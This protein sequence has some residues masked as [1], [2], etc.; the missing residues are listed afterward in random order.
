MCVKAPPSFF[1]QLF[2]K[3]TEPFYLRQ[4]A[5]FEPNTFCKYL[6]N[7]FQFR[8]NCLLSLFQFVLFFKQCVP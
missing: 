5:F 8:S 4:I 2:N 6:L 1:L 7:F 3:T